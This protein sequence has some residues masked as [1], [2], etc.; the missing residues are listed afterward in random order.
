MVHGGGDAVKVVAIV[1]ARM[2]S[3][4]LPGKVLAPVG[5]LPMIERMLGQVRASHRVDQVMIAR[6]V[7][8][9]HGRRGRCRW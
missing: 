4:R 7:P 9:V 2:S 1:Q 6:V 5:A 8:T 3:T